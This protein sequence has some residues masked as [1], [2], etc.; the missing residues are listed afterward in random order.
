MH[1]CWV[2]FHSVS[3]GAVLTLK[4]KKYTYGKAVAAVE[5]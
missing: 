2:L 5:S 1:F 3:I 4:E